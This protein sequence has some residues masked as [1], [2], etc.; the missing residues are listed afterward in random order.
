MRAII[1]TQ[2][3]SPDVLEL[4]DVSTPQPGPDE[5]LVRVR[6]ASVNPLDWHF[7]RGSPAFIRVMTGLFG[8]KDGRLGVDVAGVVEAV[9]TNVTRFQPGDQVFGAGRGSIAETVSACADRLVA[10]PANVTDE[11]AA[12][13]GVAGVT[14]LQG[15]RD[16][17]RV[18]PGQRVLVIGAAGGV[19]TF[20]V[21][22][23]KTFGAQVTGVCSARNVEMVASIG[24]DDVIDY[25]CDD[26]ARGDAR[27]DVILD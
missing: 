9:G 17:G 21:Q 8:P 12:A 15:L 23:A 4:V 3:G 5:V 22:I 7:M 6:T 11:Q 25:T 16:K 14:A 27:F 13:V 10:K 19:G 18:R 24:A 2:Y 1:Y 20:A 26:F